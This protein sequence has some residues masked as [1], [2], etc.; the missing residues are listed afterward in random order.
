MSPTVGKSRERWLKRMRR[1]LATSGALPE[2]AWRLARE[3][4]LA[5]SSWETR[6]RRI[7]DGALPPDPETI[8]RIEELLARPAT[9]ALPESSGTRQLPFKL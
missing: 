6:L 4:G 5:R 8:F 7:L 9:E 1:E 2:L 3:D